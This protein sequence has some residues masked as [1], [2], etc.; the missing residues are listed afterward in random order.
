MVFKKLNLGPIP[1]TGVPVRGPG[2]SPS[3]QTKFR[4]L[5]LGYTFSYVTPKTTTQK[6][7]TPTALP[8]YALQGAMAASQAELIKAQRDYTA[9]QKYNPQRYNPEVTPVEPLSLK[10][11]ADNHGLTKTGFEAQRNAT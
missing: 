9:A 3:T 8:P 7:P 4:K 2:P 1:K 11:W 10:S 5:D 6:N